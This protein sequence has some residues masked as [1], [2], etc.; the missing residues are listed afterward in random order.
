[1]ASSANVKSVGVLVGLPLVSPTALQVGHAH[2][3]TATCL[4]DRAG[5]P[6]SNRIYR[7]SDLVCSIALPSPVIGSSVIR[8]KR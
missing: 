3:V 4:V 1:M 8:W 6:S 5:R 2:P 7:D